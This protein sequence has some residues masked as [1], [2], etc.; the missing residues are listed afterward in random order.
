[1]KKY[2]ITPDMRFAAH[3]RLVQLQREIA[4]GDNSR[5]TELQDLRYATYVESFPGSYS[6]TEVLW[7]QQL[8]FATYWSM[9]EVNS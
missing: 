2:S 4:S 6:G 8:I 7:A 9:V 3:N 1:M 5:L